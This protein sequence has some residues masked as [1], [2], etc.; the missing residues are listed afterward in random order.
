MVTSKSELEKEVEEIKQ[1]SIGEWEAEEA[2]KAEELKWK[3][4]HQNTLYKILKYNPIDPLNDIYHKII[5]MLELTEKEQRIQWWLAEIWVKQAMRLIWRY[6]AVYEDGELFPEYGPGIIVS[7]HESHLDPF[8]VG[9]ICFHKINY[10]SKPENFKTPIVR[11]LF[12]NLSAFSLGERGNKEDIRKAWEYAKH[13][14]EMGEWIGIFPEGTRSMDESIA[15]FKTGAVRLA[16]DA[17]VPIVPVA[18]IG[19]RDA[20]PKGKLVGKP[21]QVR[22]RVGKPIYYDEYKGRL[23]PELARKLT[24]EL[25]QKVVDLKEGKGNFAKKVIKHKKPDDLDELSIGSPE[26]GKKEKKQKGFKYWLNYYKKYL[27]R[28]IDDAWLTFLKI[29]DEFGL[30]YE[31]QKLIQHGLTYP[32]VKFIVDNFA[33][34]KVMG[35]EEN[36]PSE[37]GAIICSNHNSEWDVIMNAYALEISKKRMLWQMSKQSLFQIPIVNAWVRTHHAFPLKRGESDIPCYNFAKG[38][39]EEG[40]I[41]MIYPEGTTSSGGGEVLEGHTGAMR[42]AIEAKVPIIPVGITGTENTY[43]KHAKTL[44]FGHG[45]TFKAGEPFMEHEKYFDK[46]MPDYDELKRLTNNLMSRIKDLLVYDEANA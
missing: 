5:D 40:K 24:D 1:K 4:P 43:P 25:H 12:K 30:R 7:N 14:L 32:A 16:V 9:G 42:L 39:L 21:V 19:S 11:T 6:E 22:C 34:I 23:T 27:L 35:Y 44:Y 33:P 10:M 38:L 18:V 45:Q 41:V 46:P 13:K 36:V 26:D 28:S 15:P 8:F 17:G 29:L 31:F 3:K 37:G 2:S 20:L